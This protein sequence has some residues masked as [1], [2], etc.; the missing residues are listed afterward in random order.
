M[1]SASAGR[2][3]A[4][5]RPG[6]GSSPTAG[7]P[8]TSR[9]SARSSLVVDTVPGPPAHTTTWP[10]DHEACS[11]IRPMTSAR[12]D[13]DGVL[14]PSDSSEA[15]AWS[16]ARSSSKSATASSPPAHACHALRPG[17]PRCP[18]SGG[19][20]CGASVRDPL[21]G[22]ATLLIRGPSFGH[23][24]G[25]QLQFS[26]GVVHR[27]ALPAPLSPPNGDGK[28]VAW[29]LGARP[30]RL[31]RSSGAGR[32]TARIPERRRCLGPRQRVVRHPGP[33]RESACD[34]RPSTSTANPSVLP[35]RRPMISW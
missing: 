23:R 8:T 26:C 17:C 33:S 21:P 35:F 27:S 15:T 2:P 25:R 9:R 12:S 1:L 4:A 31:H 32:Q 7:P 11:W 6:A 18:G 10:A 29:R 14:S 20:P 28:S 24:P 13:G 5:A 30:D 16:R 3:T 22:G 19:R 34:Q